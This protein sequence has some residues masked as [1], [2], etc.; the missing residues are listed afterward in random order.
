M[1]NTLYILGIITITIAACNTQDEPIEVA[2]YDDTP[3]ILDY[4]SFPPPNASNA[5]QL[6]TEKVKLGKMLFY[7]KKLSSNLTQACADCHRQEHAFTDTAQFSVGAE[8]LVGDIQAMAIFNMAWH[9]NGFFWN[10]RSPELNHQATQ[11]I[12]NPV[13]MNETIP[14][15]IT[16]L[17]AE[18]EYQ[19][20]F[21]RAFGD[22]E[23]TEERIGLALEQ[24]MF[25]FISNNSKYDKYLAGEVQLTASEERGR[26]LYFTEYN[27]FFPDESGADCAHCH[28]GIT[29]ENDQFMN[30]GIDAQPDEGRFAVTNN[31]QD[32]GRFKVTSLR[33]IEVTA[34]YMHDGRFQTLEEV[35]EHYNSGIQ[36]SPSL[37]PALLATT[38]TGLML[39]QQDKEDLVAFLKTLTDEQFLSNPEFESPF[40]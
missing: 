14:N 35:V 20:Q 9:S 22:D 30:N 38:S 12:Q 24:F 7:E 10:G 1:K 31:P 33:N 40:D 18:E 39:T 17:S 21:I 25:T 34:P 5:S 13:E 4:G 36:V 2:T 32:R 15:V 28:G 27:E 26:Q 23:I 29:F 6:T 19:N 8:G 37:D 11:P 16:K 3:Y